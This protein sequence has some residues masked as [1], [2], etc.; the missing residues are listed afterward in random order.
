MYVCVCVFACVCVCVR[1]PHFW[2]MTSR[3]THIDCSVR[4]GL[5]DLERGSEKPSSYVVLALNCARSFGMRVFVQWARRG[6]SE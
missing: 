2:G 3:K 4:G 1:A 5:G 6:H